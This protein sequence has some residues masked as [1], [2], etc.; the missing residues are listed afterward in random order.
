M[1]KTWG[2]LDGKPI[3]LPI[4]HFKNKKGT[5]AKMR[6]TIISGIVTGLEAGNDPDGYL[7]TR[8]KSA[9]VNGETMMG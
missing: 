8:H 1:T 3:F 2:I 6:P 7:E 5:G 4:G 9:S